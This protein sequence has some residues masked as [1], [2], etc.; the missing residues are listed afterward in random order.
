MTF[1]NHIILNKNYSFYTQNLSPPVYTTLLPKLNPV[2]TITSSQTTM[3]HE[4]PVLMLTTFISKWFSNGLNSLMMKLLLRID[5][6][7]ITF[8]DSLY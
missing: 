5:I 1:S 4:P 8:V 7:D 3:N 2:A 6:G